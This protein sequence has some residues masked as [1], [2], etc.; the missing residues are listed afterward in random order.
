MSLKEVHRAFARRA[1]ALQVSHA[2]KCLTSTRL[3][4]GPVFLAQPSDVRRRRAA[5][6]H[7]NGEDRTASVTEGRGAEG[8]V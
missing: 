2:Y 6:S 8:A 4:N 5:A 3:K 1:P 7:E